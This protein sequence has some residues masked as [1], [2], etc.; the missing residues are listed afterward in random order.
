MGTLE[1]VSRI[2]H[3][4][5]VLLLL[6]L[7]PA[8]RWSYQ[9]LKAGLASGDRSTLTR[10]YRRTIVRHAVVGVAFLVAWLYQGRQVSTLGLGAPGGTG[11]VIGAA[12]AALMITYATLQVLYVRRSERLQTQ[13][14]ERLLAT[15][16]SSLVP[17]TAPE[18]R[19]FA[20]V[21][22]SAGVWEELLFRGFLIAYAGHYLGLGAGV[23]AAAVAFGIGHAY[24][25]AAG[26]AK[27]GFSGLI[28]GGL[29]ALTGS[30]WI[31]MLLHTAV[32]LHAGSLGYIVKPGVTA[33]ET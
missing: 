28:A 23:V 19:L 9:R 16:L 8:A 6:V 31:P 22:L 20:G 12:I 18:Y 30:L 21:A 10:M 7:P 1:T 32:D 17:V 26:M 15:G 24:Q 29:Y 13:V 2:D 11:F 4:F 33:D 3:F 14:R 27:T 25:G 5:A